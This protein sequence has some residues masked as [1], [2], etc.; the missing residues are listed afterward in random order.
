MLQTASLITRTGERFIFRWE[1]GK[2]A[3]FFDALKEQAKN[4]ESNF[5]WFDA[6]V[7]SYLIQMNPILGQ[8][9]NVRPL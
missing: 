7:L 2:E 9:L 5:D 4:P 6:N 8:A 3:L 1:D